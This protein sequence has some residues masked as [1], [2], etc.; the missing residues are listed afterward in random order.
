MRF[1][2]LEPYPRGTSTCT[3]GRRR[4]AL[5]VPAAA[6]VF[7]RHGGGRVAMARGSAAVRAQLWSYLGGIQG[8]GGLGPKVA[9]ADSSCRKAK[10]NGFQS[11]MQ[12]SFLRDCGGHPLRGAPTA[13]IPRSFRFESRIHVTLSW[14]ASLLAS[15]RAE[16]RPSCPILCC[17]SQLRYGLRVR[18][19]YIPCRGVVGPLSIP[20]LPCHWIGGSSVSPTG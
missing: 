17:K 6:A 3:R 16:N 13:K 14:F 19:L 10:A 9:S 20:T 5:P 4:R 18:R 2:G 15:H 11:E 12:S 8:E 1:I 7:S